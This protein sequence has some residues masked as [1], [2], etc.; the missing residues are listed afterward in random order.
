MIKLKRVCRY[1]IR[2]TFKLE[3]DFSHKSD[4]VHPLAFLELI[5]KEESCMPL[6]IYDD[7]IPVGFFVYGIVSNCYV[8]ANLMINKIDQ[9]KGYA[10]RA[11]TTL[12]S[13]IKKDKNHDKIFLNVNEHNA[14]AIRLY[15]KLGFNF[16]GISHF[17]VDE[18]AGTSTDVLQMVLEY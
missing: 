14:A 1:N 12:I 7:D 5:A 6:L 17:V 8:I 4:V 11:M 3:V 16:D 18:I 15:Q 10:T 9:R 2:D 13:K